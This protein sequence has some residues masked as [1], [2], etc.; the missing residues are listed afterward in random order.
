VV[1]LRHIL[2]VGIEMGLIF[3]CKLNAKS[4]SLRNTIDGIL[5]LFPGIYYA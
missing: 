4:E 1:K 5:I 3:F 2:V